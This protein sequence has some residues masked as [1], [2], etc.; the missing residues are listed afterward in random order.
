MIDARI[1]AVVA[2]LRVLPGP[3]ERLAALTDRA[4]RLPA[5]RVD[6]RIEANRVAGCVSQVWLA[7]ECV[8][9]LMRFRADADSVMVKGLVALAWEI[10]DGQASADLATAPDEPVFLVA[11]GLDMQLSPTRLH[12]V[13]QVWRRLRQIARQSDWAQKLQQ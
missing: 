5:P 1:E 11:L 8:G 13:G 4:K 3:A 7:G 12:G 10:A 2:R 6:E 9:G